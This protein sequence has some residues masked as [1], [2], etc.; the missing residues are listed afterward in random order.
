MA[1]LDNSWARDRDIM[2]Q[3][4]QTVQ[5][6]GTFMPLKG[7]EQR[8]NPATGDRGIRAGNNDIT[9]GLPSKPFSY[10][11]VSDPGL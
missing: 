2:T 4:P 8:R 11:T 6:P 1:D 10:D 5:A 7:W 9:G 3:G